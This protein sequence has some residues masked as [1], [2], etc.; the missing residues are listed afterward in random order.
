MKADAESVCVS[1]GGLDVSLGLVSQLR[2][3][4]MSVHVPW[5]TCVISAHKA[6]YEKQPSPSPAEDP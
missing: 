5:I 6:T 4:D 2:V 1:P 3:C